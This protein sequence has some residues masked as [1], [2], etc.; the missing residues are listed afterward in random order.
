MKFNYIILSTLLITTSSLDAAAEMPAYPICTLSNSRMSSLIPSQVTET[1]NAV[2]GIAATQRYSGGV[3]W[4]HGDTSLYAL[5]SPSPTLSNSWEFQDERVSKGVDMAL[6]PCI[7]RDARGENCLFIASI[8]LDT[9]VADRAIYT[10]QEPYPISSIDSPLATTR[11]PV[12]Y[13]L[14]EG[15]EAPDARSLAVRP[16]TGSL[17]IVAYEADE[18]RVF[19]ASAPQA[20]GDTLTFRAIGKIG[21]DRPT[22]ADFSP[23]GAFLIVRNA[24]DAI[25]LKLNGYDSASITAALSAPSVKMPLEPDTDGGSITYAQLDNREYGPATTQSQNWDI[26]AFEVYTAGANGAQP[27]WRYSYN[28]S[29][30][31]PD[32]YNPPYRPPDMNAADMDTA[33][34]STADM[35][36]ADISTADMDAVDMGAADMGDSGDDEGCTS[37]GTA[38]P[39]ALLWLLAPLWA[40]IRRRKDTH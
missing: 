34:I 39:A 15:E 30:Q 7:P 37:A 35:D 8:G 9:P 16:Y 24:T 38:A 10:A 20:P 36:T 3:V 32:R 18:A 17:Y 1:I 29:C 2:N 12:M 25:E 27:L 21:L 28:Y 40:R 26:A 23:D 14:D 13:E 11:S 19:E 33:D 31:D 22:S 6:G 5:N 4:I